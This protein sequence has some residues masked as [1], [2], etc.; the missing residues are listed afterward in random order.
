MRRPSTIRALAG[1]DSVKRPSSS[2]T[3]VSNEVAS[4]ERIG[5]PSSMKSRRRMRPVRA[6]RSTTVRS[7]SH[8][9]KMAIEGGVPENVTAGSV[10]PNEARNVARPATEPRPSVVR[11][12]PMRRS[13][14]SSIVQP[15]ASEAPR[16]NGLL[17]SKRCTVPAPSRVHCTSPLRTSRTIDC[18]RAS[19]AASARTPDAVVASSDTMSTRTCVGPWATRRASVVTT[20]SGSTAVADASGSPGGVLRMAPNAAWERCTDAITRAG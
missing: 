1:G 3:S 16:P 18:G 13:G 12:P 7:P 10:G 15:E 11:S 8:P 9:G 5:L 20:R 17:W 2:S 14:Y 4:K 19:A 6:S